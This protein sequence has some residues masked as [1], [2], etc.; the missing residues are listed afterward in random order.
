MLTSRMTLEIPFANY[1]HR[2]P[3]CSALSDISAKPRIINTYEKTPYNPLTINTYKTLDLKS[4]RINTYKKTGG[5]GVLPALLGP[6][7]KGAW[8]TPERAPFGR[9]AFPG[10]AWSACGAR[11]LTRL[12][13]LSIGTSSSCTSLASVA[14][15]ASLGCGGF[16]ALGGNCWGLQTGPDRSAR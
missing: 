14:M 1:F 10:G 5:E 2:T 4:F 12:S 11:R 9:M 16:A 6:Q 8:G 13:P 3:V 7:L 15:R